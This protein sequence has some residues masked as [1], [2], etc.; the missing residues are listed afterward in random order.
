MAGIDNPYTQLACCASDLCAFML[1]CQHGTLSAAAEQMKISQPSMS[2][3]IKNLESHLNRELFVR[4]SSGME[5]NNAGQRLQDLLQGPLD[6]VAAQFQ[7]YQNDDGEARVV[8]SVDHAFAS[9]WL[10]PRLPQLREELGNTDICIH[11]S[12]DPIGNA[13]SETD[14]SIFMAKPGQVQSDATLM[15][16]ERVSVVCSPELQQQLGAPIKLQALLSENIPLLHLKNPNRKTPWID[17]A[18]WIAA[19]DLSP[20]PY[21][22]QTMF[23]S[24]EMIIKA[25]CDG[26]GVA[27]GWHK[28]IDELLASSALVKLFPDT[29]KTDTGYYIQVMTPSATPKISMV[30]DWILAEACE[31][32]QDI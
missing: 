26:Q 20:D 25:S 31:Q 7:T 16:H 9:L 6:Q 5:L 10:L 29:V 12:Q 8:I 28:L 24:Y 3:R 17:W 22:A 2:L 11:S 18:Q 19:V 13:G 1:V 27:L 23:N 32:Y 14:I 21:A 4:H 15:F 30:R